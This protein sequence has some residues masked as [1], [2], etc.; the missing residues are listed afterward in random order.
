VGAYTSLALDASD[1]P[2]ISYYYDDATNADLKY[3]WY[4]GSA[5]H[6]E[7]ADSAGNVGADTSLALDA[8]DRPHISYYDATNADLKYALQLPYTAMIYLPLALRQP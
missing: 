4:D 3:A 6:L 2:H 5:W 7:T 1:R 8:S